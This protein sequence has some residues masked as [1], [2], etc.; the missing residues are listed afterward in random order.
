MPFIEIIR[1]VQVDLSDQTCFGIK[2]LTQAARA[3]IKIVS[4]PLVNVDN[5]LRVIEARVTKTHYYGLVYVE[6][7]DSGFISLEWRASTEGSNPLGG[8]RVAESAY[9]YRISSGKEF[10][11]LAH[12]LIETKQR[13]RIVASECTITRTQA[14]ARG[15]RR[16][17]WGVKFAVYGEPLEF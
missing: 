5:H 14:K 12:M 17:I 4:L 16:L 13:C 2:K 10:E 3:M 15:D 9:A 1:G 6:E 11:R 7:F 8:H